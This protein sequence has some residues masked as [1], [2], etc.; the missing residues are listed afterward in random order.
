MM[1][2]RFHVPPPMGP[3]H[4]ATV[5]TVPVSR[6]IALSCPSQKKPSDRPS[7]DQKGFMPP[8]APWRISGDVDASARIQMRGLP[9]REF[10]TKATRVPSGDTAIGPANRYND[11]PPGS[12]R[13]R[14]AAGGSAGGAAGARVIAYAAVPMIATPA[15]NAAASGHGRRP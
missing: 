7:G 2:S 6:A 9:S 8:A 13:L 11:S 5:R 4:G 10:V 14:M 3:T 12:G 15:P 1:P